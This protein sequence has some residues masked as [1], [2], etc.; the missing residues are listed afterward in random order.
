MQRFFQTAWII[1][2]GLVSCPLAYSHV[3]AQ[4]YQQFWLWGNIQTRPYLSNATELYILQG[5]VKF[6]RSEQRSQLIPQGIGLRTFPRQQKVWLVFRATHLQWQTETTMQIIQR[7]QQWKNAG[8][9][10]IGLQIDFDSGTRNLGSYADF[11]MQLRQKLPKPYHLSIT[12]LL[13]WTN[14]QDPQTLSK[15]QQSI[16]EIV[17]QSYQGQHTIENYTQY[18]QRLKML[19]I[20][21]KLG[22]V[23][24]GTWQPPSD[25][26]S[27]PNFLGYVVFLLPKK[28]DK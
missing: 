20:P 3:D 2:L 23:E 9:Q 17:L 10:V 1:L 16:D 7:L 26:E 15:L 19:P 14:H 8:N 6:S 13:D 11:L 18:V 24:H 25:L 27:N 5:E 12:G 4:H 22:L 21:F 28:F